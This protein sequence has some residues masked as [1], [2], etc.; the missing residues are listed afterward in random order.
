[1]FVCALSV[2]LC[3][4][5]SFSENEVQSRI[6]YRAEIVENFNFSRR[7]SAKFFIMRYFAKPS[8]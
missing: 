7:Y 8:S 3:V 4:L 6:S 5:P 1:M 2:M